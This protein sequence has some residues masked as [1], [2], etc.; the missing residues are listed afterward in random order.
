MFGTCISLLP[1]LVALWLWT[2]IVAGQAVTIYAPP[3]S[4]KIPRVL[5][6][7]TT[8]LTQQ[9]E[10]NGTILATWENYSSEPP[11][12]PIYRSI[13]QGRTWSEISKVKD[14][15]NG[16]GLRYQPFL[17]EL[18]EPIGGFPVGTILLAG[19]A[20]PENLA[21]TQ[22]DLY[23]S[24]D[25]GFVPLCPHTS[26]CCF[27]TRHISQCH[28][29][30]SVSCRS[31]RKGAAQQWRDSSLGAISDDVS[32]QIGPLLFGSERPKTRPEA[33]A[34]SDGRPPKVG[35]SCR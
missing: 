6:A 23:A 9:D 10:H 2:A 21:K 14:E 19:S 1:F 22:I 18:P 8:L 17:F 34:P 15:V 16:W 32:A 7:R 30:V 26:D 28:M 12:F 25:K 3:S 29:E 13:D 5:Y 24:T 4:Y 27:L 20:I 31:W 35:T 11:Y 33:L